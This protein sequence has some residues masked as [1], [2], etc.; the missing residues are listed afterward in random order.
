MGKIYGAAAKHLIH[1]HHLVPLSK[2]RKAHRVDPVR[3][4]RPV[5]PNCHAAIHLTNPPTGIEDL[6]AT[7][8]ATKTRRR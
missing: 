8:A 3:D 7:M 1:V 5:C 2:I 4:L 6:K